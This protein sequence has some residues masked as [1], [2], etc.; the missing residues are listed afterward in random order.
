MNLSQ[1]VGVILLQQLLV[2]KQL[3]G[4]LLSPADPFRSNGG[5]SRPVVVDEEGA[6]EFRGGWVGRPVSMLL[7]NGKQT[8]IE[9][10]LHSGCGWLQNDRIP[11]PSTQI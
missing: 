10:I 5:M 2:G 8:A 3:I 6:L 9:V 1:D 11:S 4:S 7:R